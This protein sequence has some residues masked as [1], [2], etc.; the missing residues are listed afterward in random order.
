MLSPFFRFPSENSPIPSP[1]LL[2]TNLPTPASLPWNSL[3]LGHQAFTGPKASALIDVL[4]GHTLLHMG[5]EL[6]VPSCVIFGWW[7]S[8]WDLW[9]F[10][11]VHIV[12][13]SMGLQVPSAPWV[14]SLA[15][16]LGT[17]CSVQWLPL[18]IHLCICQ[19]LEG[20]CQQILVGIH[21]SV[22]V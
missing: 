14:L 1:I 16:P 17:L 9:N 6:W 3:T 7:F 19:A 11:W 21:N 4:Q 8:P 2:L 13:P 15:P 22:W 18:S 20:S 5:L 10:W 12:V